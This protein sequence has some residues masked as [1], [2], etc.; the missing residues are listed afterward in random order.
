MKSYLLFLL[1][2]LTVSLVD[3][4]RHQKIVDT[5]NNLK[6]TWNLIIYIYF[7]F[8][9]FVIKSIIFFFYFINCLTFKWIIVKLF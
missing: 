9:Y 2:N 8:F 6:T 4:E 7:Y 3:I 1:I 5:V